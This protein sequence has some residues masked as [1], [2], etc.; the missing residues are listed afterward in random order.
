[1]Y[2]Y[3]FNLWNTI[4]YIYGNDADTGTTYLHSNSLDASVQIK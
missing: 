2:T 4:I 3:I 1:M